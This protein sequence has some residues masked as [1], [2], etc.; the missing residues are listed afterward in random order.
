MLYVPEI[1]QNLLSVGKLVEKGYKV[2]FENK[3]C[4]IKNVE[5]KD[6]LK[7]KMRGKNFALDPLEEE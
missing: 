4:L 6:I 3:I 1:Y 2:L 5:A 7:V